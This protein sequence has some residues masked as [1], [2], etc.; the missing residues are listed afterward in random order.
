M[1]KKVEIVNHTADIGIRVY[2]EN[3]EELFKNSAEGLYKIF[4][5]KY[6]KNKEET[7]KIEL[8]G[9]DLENLL[10]KFL[11]E[12]IYYIET[13]KKAGK[14]EKLE[15]KKNNIYNLNAIIKMKKVE[16]I[17][18]EIKAATYHNLK[19]EEKGNKCRTTI[20]FDL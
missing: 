13:K 16:R 4:G 8:T 1:K 5:I 17:E 3:I 12:L 6:I 19:I 10:V 14:I 11:N 18:K 9:E 20:I 2:G 15:I 7:L